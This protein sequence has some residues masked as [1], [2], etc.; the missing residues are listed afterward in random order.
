LNNPFVLGQAQL[1]ADR[2]KREAGDDLA[3]QIELAYQ[4]ALTRP[5]TEV[6]LRVAFGALT[7]GSLADLTHVL[8]NLN[9]FAYIR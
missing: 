6:E 8:F 9:E 7:S 1:F 5:P 2:V 3:R 4:I